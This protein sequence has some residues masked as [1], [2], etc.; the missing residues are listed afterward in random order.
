MNIVCDKVIYINI[1]IATSYV[2]LAIFSVMI[3]TRNQE[4]ILI[5]T[6]RVREVSITFSERIFMNRL[7]QGY[8]ETIISY[9]WNGNA[10]STVI[11]LVLRVRN[12]TLHLGY[13]NCI[14]LTFHTSYGWIQKYILIEIL[15]FYCRRILFHGIHNFNPKIYNKYDNF[16][17]SRGTK[18]K[19]RGL[20]QFRINIHF[21]I[22]KKF[23]IFI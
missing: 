15:R 23:L 3:L 5:V 17:V 16:K 12:F 11:T 14:A 4:V 10:N 2:A 8:F 19:Q 21:T 1:A 18:C 22:I 6:S 7:E 9:R 13:K 20:I